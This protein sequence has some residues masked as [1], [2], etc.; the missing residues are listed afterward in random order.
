[1]FRV[2]LFLCAFNSDYFLPNQLALSAGQCYGEPKNV[3]LGRFLL[4][5]LQV[6]VARNT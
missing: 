4:R 6:C 3:D 2:F 5:K 1:M